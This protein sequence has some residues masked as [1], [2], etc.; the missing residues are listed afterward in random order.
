MDNYL[1]FRWPEGKDTRPEPDE[2]KKKQK[3]KKEKGRRV[4]RDVLVVLAALIVLCGLVAGSFFGV[5]YVAERMAAELPG[6]TIVPEDSLPA[7]TPDVT[8]E[9]LWSA[10]LLP[11]GAEDPS[12][13]LN[14]LSREGE[15]AL[16]A[17]EIYKKV[18]PSIVCVEAYNETGYSVGS[19]IVISESGYILTN[20]HIIEGGTG[21]GIMLLTDWSVYD[22]TLVGYDKELDLAVLKA[23]GS[24]FVPAQ[25]G[26]SDE[27]EVGDPVY[28]IGNPL[29][30]LYGAMSD[31]MV[32]YLGDRVAQLDYP[33]RLI[34]TTAALNSGNSGGALVD[35]Y[36]R[37]VGITYAKLTGIRNDTVVEG[38]G[39][40]IP[41]SDARSYINRILRTGDSARPSLGIQC[42]SPVEVDGV[43][44]IQVAEAT[45]G[46]PAYG[47]LLPNDLIIAANGIRVY[48]VDDMARILS[49]MD[50]GDEVELTVIRKG[51]EITV[52]V[53]LYDRL[54]ELQ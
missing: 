28:A 35:A 54:P 29:G 11:Q 1:S 47:K 49:E 44:G 26:N 21:L 41:I 42:Y 6:Q 16:D 17:T 14:L 38:L 2:K 32:S 5:Q 46:T 36:G 13:Q 8:Q 20:Y 9:D 30:Y 3:Q 34:Q 43:I 24:G 50:P 22:A 18:L 12:V 52:V 40:A 23:E 48:T 19:G 27:L 51:K 37:V 4:W 31:G 33:G 10:D 15:Q 25:F 45:A 53:E 7:S 39:L